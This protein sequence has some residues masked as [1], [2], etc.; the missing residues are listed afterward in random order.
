L[1]IGNS[2]CPLSFGILFVMD[3]FICFLVVSYGLF[4]FSSWW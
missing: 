3:V 1:V 2:V 4:L